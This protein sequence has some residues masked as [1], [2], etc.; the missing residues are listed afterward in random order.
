[1]ASNADA[2]VICQ[3]QIEIEF[4]KFTLDKKVDW[5]FFSSSNAVIAYFSFQ[6]VDKNIKY[7]AIGR[8]TART[9]TK[10]VEPNFVGEGEVKAAAYQFSKVISATDIVVFPSSD[11][12]KRSIQSVLPSN[13]TVDVVAYKTK[14]TPTKIEPCDAYI[15]T[16]P[17]NVEAFFKLNTIADNASLVAIGNST[18]QKLMEYGHKSKISWD[19]TNLALWDSV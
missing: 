5:I 8:G 19:Y 1:M 15:F 12:S 14:L 18:A 9:L 13:Q 17:S 4:V 11:R 3:P 16:S 7:A 10:Y 2:K 6:K